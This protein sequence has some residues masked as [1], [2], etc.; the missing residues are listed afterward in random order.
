M[1]YVRTAQQQ[2]SVARG[3]QCSVCPLTTYAVHSSP[4]TDRCSF[5][6]LRASGETVAKE[7]G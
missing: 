1:M 3:T 4:E 2:F 7:Q 5:L 6:V